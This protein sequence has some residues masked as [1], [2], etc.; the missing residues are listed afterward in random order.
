MFDCKFNSTTYHIVYK[1]GSEIVS[2]FKEE[3]DNI[4]KV[5]INK[6]KHYFKEDLI[7]KNG[8]LV[9]SDILMYFG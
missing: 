1:N 8:E 3:M 5:N 2:E 7:F 6:I 9:L 4:F